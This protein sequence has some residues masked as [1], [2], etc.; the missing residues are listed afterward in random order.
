MY[1]IIAG[2]GIAGS[3][4]AAALVERDHDVVVIDTNPEACEALYARTGA[5]TV[6]G[7]ATEIATLEEAGIDR[8]DCA[9]GALYRDAD[10][11][12]FAVLA[13]A[14]GVEQIVVKMRDPAYE[15][16]Y[17]SA[18]VS[19]ICDMIGLFRGRVLAAVEEPG[20]EV[21]AP[22]EGGQAHLVMAE[23]PHDWPEAGVRVAELARQGAFAR[24]CVLAGILPADG[25]RIVLPR[26]GDRVRP[27]DR[28]FLVVHKEQAGAVARLLRP[29]AAG[30][31][32]PS[33]A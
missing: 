19:T 11:L 18:G 24:D 9:I 14:H 3:S 6:C 17:R 27:G 15:A 16:V 5:V 13:R 22:L 28:L 2:G 26:G 8:A 21:L 30:R 20:L 7:P 1:V 12:T 23:A 10:N 32:A 31:L 25:E 29:G 4:L 33:P